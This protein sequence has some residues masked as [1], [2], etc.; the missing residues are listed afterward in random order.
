MISEIKVRRR[1]LDGR[2]VRVYNAGGLAIIPGSPA[3]LRV[4]RETIRQAHAELAEF[5]G[6]LLCGRWAGVIVHRVR[7]LDPRVEVS[8][9][10]VKE[11]W[12]D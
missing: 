11:A 2:R 6:T 7:L 1:Q 12:G 8:Q 10:I 9:K 3:V 5:E 4:L